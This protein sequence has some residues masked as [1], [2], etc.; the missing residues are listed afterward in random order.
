MFDETVEISDG[1]D[2][3]IFSEGRNCLD[4]ERSRLLIPATK[5]NRNYRD[6]R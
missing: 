2:D 6:R 3:R 1:R 5:G 4:R